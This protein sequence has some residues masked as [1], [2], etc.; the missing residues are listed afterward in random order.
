MSIKKLWMLSVV[1]ALAVATKTHGQVNIPSPQFGPKGVEFQEN[2][3]PMAELG[4]FDYDAQMFAPVEFTN[5]KELEPST[6]FFATYDRMYTSVSR[7]SA[8]E[9]LPAGITDSSVPV[10][11]DFMWGNR[12]EVGWMTTADDGYQLVYNNASGS[13]FS[14]GQDDLIGT[15]FMVTTQVSN[16]ALNRIFRQSTEAGG[17][18]EP[19]VGLK[20]FNLSDK[21]IEDTQVIVGTATLSNRFKQ[22][23]TNSAIGGQVG[24]RFNSK[25]ARWRYTFDGSLSAMYNQQRYFATDILFTAAQTGFGASESYDSDQSFVP[26]ADLRFE[27][28]YLLTRDF[29]IRTGV[30]VQYLWDGLARSDNLTTAFNPNSIQ[31]IGGGSTGVFDES[32]VAA[33]FSFGVEWKR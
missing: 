2:T 30:Q 3:R 11:S 22:S 27:L 6:G 17:Y 10:G 9:I 31:G 5:F 20:Y 21:T 14:A 33:G 32:T 12:F 29:G 4:S 26:A 28:A 13:W 19:Y 16:V 7:G 8:R 24:A 18:F 1:V 25:K 15:P 23:V